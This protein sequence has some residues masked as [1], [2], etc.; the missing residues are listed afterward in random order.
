ML[1]ALGPC[2]GLLSELSLKQYR[3]A[4]KA[5]DKTARSAR[6]PPGAK[7]RRGTQ[8]N[9]DDQG[10]SVNLPV[11]GSRDV[12]TSFAVNVAANFGAHLIV[13]AS[14]EPTK[15]DEL[16][17]AD[18]AHHLARH[19]VKVE[20]ERNRIN[21]GRHRQHDPFPCRGS[22][23]GSPRHGRIRSFADA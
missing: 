9:R 23:R 6:S 22:F 4:W 12:V 21:G 8:R 1:L 10:H 2:R 14:G 7:S 20:V 16:P 5:T 3:Q 18:I 11:D 15:S 19:G 13:I 17:G